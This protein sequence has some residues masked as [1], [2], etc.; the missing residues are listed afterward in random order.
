MS[1]TYLLTHRQIRRIEALPEGHEV[2]STRYGVPIVRR[3]DGRL[4]RV[5]PNG[6]MVPTVGVQRV[7]SYLDVLE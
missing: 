4:L 2:V 1:G 5:Q 3:P 6:R 7:Q